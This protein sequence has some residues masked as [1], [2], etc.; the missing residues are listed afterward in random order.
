MMS[1]RLSVL[2]GVVSGMRRMRSRTWVAISGEREATMYSYLVFCEV[3]PRVE[4]W[5]STCANHKSGS[6]GQKGGSL[7]FK[8]ATAPASRST[9][10][11]VT[12]W[13]PMSWYDI[14]YDDN[15]RR[16][17]QH[18]RIARLQLPTVLECYIQFTTWS[19]SSAHAHHKVITTGLW[20]VQQMRIL[21]EMLL[22]S[23]V[24]ISPIQLVML[25]LK[26]LAV[27]RPEL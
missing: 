3:M 20:F 23:T 22:I 13:S 15:T 21:S 25:T 27:P 18:T 7:R 24:M 14:Y 26:L 17:T 9:D 8:A 4:N 6:D 19:N 11:L 12:S 16:E 5:A 10:I 1:W 2:Y